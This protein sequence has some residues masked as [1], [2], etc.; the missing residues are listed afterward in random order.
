MYSIEIFEIIIQLKKCER[1]DNAFINYKFSNRHY[2]VWNPTN[3]TF[4]TKSLN[5]FFETLL[6]MDDILYFFSFG[7]IFTKW[8]MF[9]EFF[10]NPNFD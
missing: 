5:K 8:W 3:K 2:W 1:V 4:V 6:P 9:F 7:W 10:I